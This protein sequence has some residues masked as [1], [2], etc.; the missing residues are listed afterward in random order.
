MEAPIILKCEQNGW[1]WDQMYLF[2]SDVILTKPRD[3]V[4][5]VEV[6]LEEIRDKY[7]WVYLGEE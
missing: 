5:D 3:T 6:A 7:A 4:E 1:G 2:E